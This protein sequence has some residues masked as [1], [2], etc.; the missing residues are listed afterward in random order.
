M[1]FAELTFKQLIR[2]IFYGELPRQI[3]QKLNYYPADS[4]YFK[5]MT[6]ILSNHIHFRGIILKNLIDHVIFNI[7]NGYFL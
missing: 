5:A 2:Q 6:H 1:D 7:Q 3:T 4:K